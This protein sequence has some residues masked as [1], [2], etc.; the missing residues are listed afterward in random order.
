MPNVG[1]FLG[2]TW[3]SVRSLG[4]KRMPGGYTRATLSESDDHLVTATWWPRGA[5][6]EIHGHGTSHASLRVLEGE[7][8]EERWTRGEEGAWTYA[9]RALRAGETSEL[10]PGAVHRLAA[11]RGASVV[12][13]FS[14]PPDRPLERVEARVLPMLALARANMLGATTTSV[15]MSAPLPEDVGESDA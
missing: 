1:G 6:S 5:A 8:V 13:T 12:T 11:I 2:M 15:E 4:A 7:I 10:P 14:P 9:R 3:D